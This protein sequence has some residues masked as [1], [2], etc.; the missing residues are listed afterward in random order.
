[1][2]SFENNQSMEK[3]FLEQP[4]LHQVSEKK[5]LISSLILSDVVQYYDGLYIF[6]EKQT[7]FFFLIQIAL[8]LPI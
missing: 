2:K 1:M 5:I 3:V 4:R 6:K 8:I 7:F